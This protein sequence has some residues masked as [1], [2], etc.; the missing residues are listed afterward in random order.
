[1]LAG[2]LKQTCTVWQ[3]QW[4]PIT[5]AGTAASTIAS[6]SP[7]VPPEFLHLH[8]QGI[9]LSHGVARGA[10]H[11]HDGLSTHEKV[12]ACKCNGLLIR[13]SDDCDEEEAAP[14]EGYT[15]YLRQREKDGVS[16]WER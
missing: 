3:A 7:A 12:G 2:T 6:T 16:L 15:A 9:V 11:L 1:M 5:T 14:S 8:A 13:T 4:A 10:P